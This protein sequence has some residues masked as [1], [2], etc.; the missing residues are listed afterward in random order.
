MC[1][2]AFIGWAIKK[3]FAII[4]NIRAGFAISLANLF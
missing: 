2:I 3:N 4:A 1:I